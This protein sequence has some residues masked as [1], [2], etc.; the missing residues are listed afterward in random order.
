MNVSRS[1]A[2]VGTRLLSVG[3]NISAICVFSK[4]RAGP[5][6]LRESFGNC[7]RGGDYDMRNPF[8]TLPKKTRPSTVEKEKKARVIDAFQFS[9]TDRIRQTVS[10]SLQHLLNCDIRC[11]LFADTRR[12]TFDGASPIILGWSGSSHSGQ[13]ATTASSCHRVDICRRRGASSVRGINPRFQCS[14]SMES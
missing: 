8:E 11:F 5:H 6:P 1:Q 10:S 4:G 12:C 2:L 14:E 9:S 7:M 3:D 13:D